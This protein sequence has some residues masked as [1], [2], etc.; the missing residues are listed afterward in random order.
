MSLNP[1]IASKMAQLTPG[2]FKIKYHISVGSPSIKKTNNPKLVLDGNF[3]QKHLNTSVSSQYYFSQWVQH[4]FF[5]FSHPPWQLRPSIPPLPFLLRINTD[6][7]SLLEYVKTLWDPFW[8]L[9]SDIL[10]NK[11]FVWMHRFQRLVR[12][13]CWAQTKQLS[14]KC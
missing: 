13:K 9:N 4:L 2:R 1:L 6:K 7:W 11:L 5:L 8:S 14:K 10:R 12:R 3:H